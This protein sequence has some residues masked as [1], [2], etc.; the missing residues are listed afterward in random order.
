MRGKLEVEGRRPR[1][2]L[3]AT[4]RAEGAMLSALSVA[5]GAWRTRLARHWRGSCGLSG[6]RAPRPGGERSHLTRRHDAC[7]GPPG[8]SGPA[9]S[10]PSP[11]E[12]V[13]APLSGFLHQPA[14]KAGAGLGPSAPGSRGPPCSPRAPGMLRAASGA[15]RTPLPGDRDLSERNGEGLGS[16]I[17]PESKSRALNQFQALHLWLLESLKDSPER[18]KK[19]QLK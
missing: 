6:P 17:P 4:C 1:R 13:L 9:P 18:V 12:A 2:N 19:M 14:R 5:G 3:R 15:A 7:S 11:A 10:R 16:S 8:A